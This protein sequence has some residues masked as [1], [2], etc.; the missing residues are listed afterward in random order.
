M[1]RSHLGTLPTKNW[2]ITNDTETLIHFFNMSIVFQSWD[3]Y[4]RQ[5]MGEAEEYGWPV[6]RHMMLVYPNNSQVYTE[7]LRYQFMV[8]TELLVAPVH[9][10]IESF[11]DEIPVFLPN[12]TSWVHLWS[13]ATYTGIIT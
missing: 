7:D 6:A 10:R 13:G 8:G 1:Y 3:F 2:Q 9:S 4:R 11:F 12:N 5:L